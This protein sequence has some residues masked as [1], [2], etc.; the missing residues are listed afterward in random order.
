MQMNLQQ[1]LNT[2]HQE[3]CLGIL[4]PTFCKS[5]TMT[6]SFMICGKLRY[7]KV[8][9]SLFSKCSTNMVRTRDVLATYKK[10]KTNRKEKQ[11]REFFLKEKTNLQANDK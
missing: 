4:I 6:S 2:H 11:P 7:A 10:K 8:M 5:T 1:I 9:F 3:H